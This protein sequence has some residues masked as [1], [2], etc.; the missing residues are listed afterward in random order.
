MVSRQA[1]P[2]VVDHINRLFEE[3]NLTLPERTAIILHITNSVA[4][5]W[6]DLDATVMLSM[7]LAKGVP[8]LKAWAAELRD[9]A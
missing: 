1:H 2:D 8:N 7:M 9:A 3:A 4:Q 5:V 6:S